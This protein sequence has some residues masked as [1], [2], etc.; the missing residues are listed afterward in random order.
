MANPAACK[1]SMSCTIAELANHVNNAEHCKLRY[2]IQ[3]RAF[4]RTCYKIRNQ[5]IASSA[6][7]VG[8]THVS[9][10][11]IKGIL[12]LSNL[13]ILRSPRT[14]LPFLR[15]V[16]WKRSHGSSKDLEEIANVGRLF[17]TDH[18]RDSFNLDGKRIKS[19]NS[20]RFILFIS[21]TTW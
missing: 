17:A 20:R 13:V 6:M 21:Y 5:S 12:P 2:H 8:A 7:V 15:G 19:G 11:S 10:E 1:S 4:P 9:R 18:L 3:E 16:L 14:K